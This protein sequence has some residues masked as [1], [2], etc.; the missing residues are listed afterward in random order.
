MNVAF[1]ALGISVTLSTLAAGCGGR[2]EPKGSER[3]VGGSS[4]RDHASAGTP[5]VRARAPQRVP[6]SP[7][8]RRAG[9]SACAHASPPA[10]LHRYLTVARHHSRGS[11]IRR[12]LIAQ[13]T[14]M[15]KAVRRSPAAAPVAAALYAI[16]KPK[17]RR[18]GAFA[19][20]MSE[21]RKE[22]SR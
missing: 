22:T 16:T 21:L 1:L 11:A 9:Q 15:P 18:S 14:H 4:Q 5:T 17:A 2:E 12:G 7:A 13:A 8:A 3:T 19:G 10:V 20:C 6:I